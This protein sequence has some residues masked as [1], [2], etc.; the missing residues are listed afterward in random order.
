MNESTDLQ[1]QLI[2]QLKSLQEAAPANPWQQQTTQTS[3]SNPVGLSVPLKIDGVRVYMHFSA[4][5]AA[6]PQAIMA[7]IE[8]LDALGAP[9]DRWKPRQNWGG[10]GN[11]GYNRK[12]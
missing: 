9:V 8:Q 6:S 3:A 4:D 2:E 5:A 11:S 10:G 12:W 7:V 1:K